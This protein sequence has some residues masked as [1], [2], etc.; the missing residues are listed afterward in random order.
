MIL[1]GMGLA[2]NSELAAAVSNAGSLSVIGL[3]Y[4]H[5]RARKT[6]DR[7][8]E[9]IAALAEFDTRVYCCSYETPTVAVLFV[10]PKQSRIEQVGKYFKNYLGLHSDMRV[11]CTK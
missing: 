3:N 4:Q 5:V 2:G 10:A 8:R 7:V 1:G 11:Y 9:L 6:E